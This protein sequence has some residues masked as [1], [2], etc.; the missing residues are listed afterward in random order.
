MEGQNTTATAADLQDKVILDLSQQLEAKNKI[1]ASLE[2]EVAELK[3]EKGASPKAQTV[4]IGKKTYTVSI[5]R[6]NFKG[7][8][9]TASDVANDQKLAAELVEEQSGVLVEVTN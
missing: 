8:S 7:K 4:K 6:F 2:A 1:I 9:Y 5:P 3:A